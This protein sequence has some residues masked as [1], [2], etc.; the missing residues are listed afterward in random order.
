MNVQFVIMGG[1][2][3]RTPSHPREDHASTVYV[4]EV[5][6][7]SSR[8]VPFIS[9]VT[10]VPLVKLATQAMLGH[11][12]AGLGYSGG[13]YPPRGLVGIKAPVFSTAKLGGVDTYLGP[14]M[15][16]TGEVMG[17]DHTFYSALTKA[18][19][20]AGLLLPPKGSILMS[21]ADRDK[22]A[23]VP[24]IRALAQS[25]YRFYATE[26]TARLIQEQGVREVMVASKL[27]PGE[28]RR[29][30]VVDVIRQGEVDAVVNT[31]S[32]G[33]GPIQDGFYIRRAAVE[34]R[35]PCFT[36][37]DTA[38]AAVELLLNGGAQYQVK[39]LSEYLEEASTPP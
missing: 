10:G 9:K 26:G 33:R 5:N 11:R 4:L 8:T 32:G 28:L 25:G 6:P 34:Q 18:L 13:L 35:I 12:L 39:R 30:T 15:K 24:L 36:S 2:P 31:L 21:V 16:S 19:V 20:A 27:T 38:S 29:P 3:Y 1:P 7:R 37:L 14:E 22:Q 17:I 23:A